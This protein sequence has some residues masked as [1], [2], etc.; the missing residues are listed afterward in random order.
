MGCLVLLISA[1]I[2][3]GAIFGLLAWLFG[4]IITVL[5]FF[6]SLGFWG[7]IAILVLCAIVAALN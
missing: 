7:I 3:R 1:F 2:F 4:A 6:L 5:T